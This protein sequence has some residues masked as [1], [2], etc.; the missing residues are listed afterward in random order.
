MNIIANPGVQLAVTG[1]YT[2]QGCIFPLTAVAVVP[3]ICSGPVAIE[4][5]PEQAVPYGA[6]RER[7]SQDARFTVSF[8]K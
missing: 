5:V 6:H 2:S 1:V 7:E 3:P 8:V 4:V